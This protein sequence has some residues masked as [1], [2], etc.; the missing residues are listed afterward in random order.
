M[1]TM[2][3]QNWKYMLQTIE[4]HNIIQK[5]TNQQNMENILKWKV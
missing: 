3:F 5:R 4:N 1:H 2:Q